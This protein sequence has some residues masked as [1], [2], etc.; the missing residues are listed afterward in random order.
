MV[1]LTP[2]N[3][4]LLMANF[5]ISFRLCGL[6]LLGLREMLYKKNKKVNTQIINR[7]Y[8]HML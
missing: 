1:R 2:G 6:D 5:S 8:V 7:V 4:I 3:I